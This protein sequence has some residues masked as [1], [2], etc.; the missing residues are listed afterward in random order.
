MSSSRTRGRIAL[1]GILAVT[2]LGSAAPAQAD[3]TD[4]CERRLERIEHRF[5]E[6]EARRGYDAA[7]KWWENAWRRY[8]D[9]CVV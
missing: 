3:K 4:R 9:R 6:I 2:A 5:R 1:A 7:T 8:H